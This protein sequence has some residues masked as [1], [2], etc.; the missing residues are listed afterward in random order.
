M[1]WI[2][3]QALYFL[4][5]YLSLTVMEVEP[6]QVLEIAYSDLQFIKPIGRGSAGSV[7]QGV[8]KSKGLEVA[9]KRVLV[10]PSMREIQ[11]LNK[12][13]HPNV[14]TFY[15]AVTVVHEFSIVTELAEMGS[16]FLYLKEHPEP[17][18]EQSMRWAK[19]VAQG[20]RYLHQNNIIHRD[21]KSGNVLLTSSLAAKICDFGSAKESYHDS[22]IL[23]SKTGTVAWMSPEALRKDRISKAWDVY[24][25][26]VL[27]WELQTHQVP[28]SGI[29]EDVLRAKVIAGERPQIPPKKVIPRLAFLMQMCWVGDP[30]RR[31]EFDYII[32]VLI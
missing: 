15:G 3:I 18:L 16:L 9:I 5:T 30:K 23:S 28:F 13:R 26:G 27:L 6:G 14:I 24:S 29:P 4:H 1:V 31:P 11:I 21:L 8:W 19:E 22:T 17:C 2:T 32:S 10:Y 20:I 25:Y 12:L 7:F